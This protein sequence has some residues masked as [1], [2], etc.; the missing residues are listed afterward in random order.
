M[1]RAQFC[2]ESAS[3]YACAQ[4]CAG[5][6]SPTHCGVIGGG[7]A[8][9]ASTMWLSEAGNRVTLLE[10]R[11]SLG[12]RTIAMPLEVHGPRGLGSHPHVEQQG[13][14]GGPAPCQVMDR[15]D[16]V[17]RCFRRAAPDEF[18]HLFPGER[19]IG[20]FRAPGAG[21]SGCRSPPSRR[22]AATARRWPFVCLLGP[23][24]RSGCD[25]IPVTPTRIGWLCSCRH[26]PVRSWPQVPHRR[27]GRVGPRPSF[28]AVHAQAR[29]RAAKPS[30]RS[31]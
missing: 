8:G 24:S 31:P 13:D 2:S 18:G 17:V 4:S 1:Q 9:L 19:E 5:C 7:L 15:L 16:R 28:A 27:A 25:R 10:R 3:G 14:Q 30:R 23:R 29:I 11:G 12:G 21:E 26:P 22:P 6:S 20:E